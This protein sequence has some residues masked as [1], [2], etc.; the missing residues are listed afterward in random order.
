M[1]A[2]FM[3]IAPSGFYRSSKRAAEDYIEEYQKDLNL[4]SSS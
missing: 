1:L 2:Q 3:L 4:I